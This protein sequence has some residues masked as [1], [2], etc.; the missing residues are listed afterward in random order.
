[1]GNSISS[2]PSLNPDPAS[3]GDLCQ[4]MFLEGARVLG[5]SGE[6]PMPREVQRQLLLAA[7]LIAD[8]LGI[9]LEQ[10]DDAERELTG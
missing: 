2:K 5:F 7:G 1:M 8:G 6:T 9:L 10:D 4:A 3:L